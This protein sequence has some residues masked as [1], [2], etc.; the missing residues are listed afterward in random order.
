[1]TRSESQRKRFLEYKAKQMANRKFKN[2]FE[3]GLDTLRLV[4]SIVALREKKKLSQT[5]L[6]AKI[7]TS[8][9]VISRLA[10]GKNV[11]LQTIARTLCVKIE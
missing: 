11:E 6:A 5:E 9:A 8:Q 10:R 7:H 2:A 3:E 1:M 4:A